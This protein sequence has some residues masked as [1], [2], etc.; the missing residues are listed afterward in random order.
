MIWYITRS[1]QR[2]SMRVNVIHEL[3]FT[4]FG[5]HSRS[6]FVPFVLPDIIS[7]RMLE[8]F[9]AKSEWNYY[10]EGWDLSTNYSIINAWGWQDGNLIFRARKSFDLKTDLWKMLN[11]LLEYL[12]ANRMMPKKEKKIVGKCKKITTSHRFLNPGLDSTRCSSCTKSFYDFQR[13]YRW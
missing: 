1:E 6:R 5:A 2:V 12:K 7:R 8:S 4:S 11:N 10:H 13:E 9:H 3:C